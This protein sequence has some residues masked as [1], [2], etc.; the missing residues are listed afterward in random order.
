VETA[1]LVRIER[2]QGALRA[3][4]RRPGGA[5]EQRVYEAIILCT[6]PAQDI[7]TK[8]PLV[9]ALFDAGHAR[10]DTVGIGL[11]VD[12]QSRLKDRDGNVLPGL[13]AFGPMTRGTFGEM[14]GAP[15]IARHLGRVLKSGTLFDAPQS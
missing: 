6:G 9:R 8:N 5:L 12:P 11:D 15:D 2:A 4:L 7:A 10:L 1:G 14:T 13:F 3:T